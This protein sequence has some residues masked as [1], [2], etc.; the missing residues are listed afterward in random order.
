[1]QP[2]PQSH[3]NKIVMEIIY[4][5]FLQKINIV[6]QDEM[7]RHNRKVVLPLFFNIIIVKAFR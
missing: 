7:Y 1:M 5:S 2:L 6:Q 4:I 3:H